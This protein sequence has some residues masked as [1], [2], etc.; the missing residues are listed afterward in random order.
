LIIILC[1]FI[2]ASW[3]ALIF[4]SYTDFAYGFEEVATD[5]GGIK[6]VKTIDNFK[7]EVQKPD[8]LN[9]NGFLAIRSGSFTV[10]IT[11]EGKLIYPNTP[12]ISL[13]IWPGIF[14]DKEYGLMIDFE[15]EDSVEQSI[16]TFSKTENGEYIINHNF[17][18]E[19]VIELYIEYE[20]TIKEMIKIAE[21]TWD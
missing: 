8:F 21:N 1:S 10:K 11:S 6:Y 20:E 7:L 4:L 16:I 2:C 15:K 5:F 18:D 19:K 3:Y 14:N 13:F 9:N 17:Q 12:N